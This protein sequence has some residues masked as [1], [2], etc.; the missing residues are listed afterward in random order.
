MKNALNNKAIC[1]LGMHRSGTSSITRGLNLMG[2]YLGEPE[3]MLKPQ[4]DNPKGFWEHAGL[5]DIHERMLMTLSSTWDD[6][7]PLE[8][9]WWKHREIKQLKEELICLLLREF[10]DKP[11]WG[12]KD[13]RTCIMLPL[14]KEI[15]QELNFE[16][17]FL[18]ILRN[19]IDIA[20]SLMNRNNISLNKSYLL[21]KL[22]ILSALEVTKDA[23]RFII[24]Y[25]EFLDNW[26]H[27][28]LKVS[29]AFCIPWPIN[30]CLLN[31]EM[32]SFLD[33]GLQHSQSSL[34]ELSYDI[35]NENLSESIVSLYE[36][37]LKAEENQDVAN[38]EEF[39]KRISNMYLE[40]IAYMRMIGSEVRLSLENQNR[41]IL[42]K[43]ELLREQN[44]LIS[45]VFNT[46]SWKVTKP[47][48][49]LG[50][51]LSRI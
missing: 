40:H 41:L 46:W 1:V 15:S 12:W 39:K 20:I 38:S 21:W 29:K 32:E 42:E 6:I 27:T 35:E 28:L 19:P 34:A 7:W 8:S 5:V 48:R 44:K 14:W 45:G 37:C 30:E 18:I 49:W 25:E 26:K 11:L 24:S 47:L 43:D 36:L 9:E 51:L 31:S 33:K 2:V 16:L 22:Y 4:F 17:A 23:D 10:A 13:P 3:R 50:D